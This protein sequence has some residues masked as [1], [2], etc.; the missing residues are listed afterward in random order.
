M[1]RIRALCYENASERDATSI[2]TEVAEHVICQGQ[3]RLLRGFS[4]QLIPKAYVAECSDVLEWKVTD[5]V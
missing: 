4:V 2:T 5:I 1:H 3:N